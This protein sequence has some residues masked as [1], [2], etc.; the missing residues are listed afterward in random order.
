MYCRKCGAEIPD[1]AVFCPEC[2][3]R[4]IKVS[5][6]RKTTKTEEL[7]KNIQK[8]KS[9]VKTKSTPRKKGGILKPLLIVGVIAVLGI[10]GKDLFTEYFGEK[11]DQPELSVVIP[12]DDTPESTINTPVPSVKP[13]TPVQNTQ[14]IKP[15]VPNNTVTGNTSTDTTGSG[16]WEED[17]MPKTIHDLTMAI[18]DDF[19]YPEKM[20]AAGVPQ[21]AE[22][23][24][25]YKAEGAW[26]YEL[27]FEENN[28]KEIGLCELIFGQNGVSFELY[29][30]QSIY[31]YDIYPTDRETIGYDTYTGSMRDEDYILQDSSESSTIVLSPFIRIEGTEYAFGSI[32][33]AAGDIGSFLFTRP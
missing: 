7:K 1:E 12:A 26:K 31:G 23:L 4:V 16:T 33:T 21:S 17:M 8:E 32:A 6:N 14:T 15:S 13:E 22:Y 9:V 10:A 20:L 2:G 18:T 5:E 30:S 11:K 27:I 29:P 3:E 25:P 28:Y 19:I 24:Q